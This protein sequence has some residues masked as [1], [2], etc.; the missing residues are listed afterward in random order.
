MWGSVGG[1]LL[2][3]NPKA[4]RLLAG[5]TALDSLIRWSAGCGHKRRQRGGS[6]QNIAFYIIGRRETGV[7]ALSQSSDS[8]Q[9]QAAS[10]RGKCLY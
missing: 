4:G 7:R 3:R 8:S 10:P 1:K 6:G 5:L 2:R 9:G